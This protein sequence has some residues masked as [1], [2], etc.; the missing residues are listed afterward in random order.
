M[1]LTV[2]RTLGI[3]VNLVRKST[4]IKA[5]A[6]DHQNTQGLK[7]IIHDVPFITVSYL[8]GGHFLKHVGK[9]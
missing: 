6:I 8:K 2:K 1:M 5:G 7:A 9:C 4:D 3:H